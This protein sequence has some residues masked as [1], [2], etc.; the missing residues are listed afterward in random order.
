MSQIALA[1]V[2]SPTPESGDGSPKSAI[3]LILKDQSSFI[4]LTNSSAWSSVTITPAIDAAALFVNEP[5]IF[6]FKWYLPKDEKITVKMKLKINVYLES[7]NS[8]FVSIISVI[9]IAYVSDTFFKT[10]ENSLSLF[11]LWM[12]ILL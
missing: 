10:D 11:L 3:P 12:S 8:F 2:A 7:S 4:P 9:N 6:R 5:V 1:F